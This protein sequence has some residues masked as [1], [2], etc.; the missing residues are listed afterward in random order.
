M[1]IALINSHETL[2]EWNFTFNQKKYQKTPPK[3]IPLESLSCINEKVKWKK[4]QFLTPTHGT[5]IASITTSPKFPPYQSGFFLGEIWNHTKGKELA[6]G[7]KVSP[8]FP[9]NALFFVLADEDFSDFFF[10]KRDPG[11]V[12]EDSGGNF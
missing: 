6:D 5:K 2:H 11:C 9:K 8:S 7:E 10:E 1:N 3:S 4:N 12:I